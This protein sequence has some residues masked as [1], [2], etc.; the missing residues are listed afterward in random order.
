[1]RKSKVSRRKHSLLFRILILLCLVTALYFLQKEYK[2]EVKEK[3]IQPVKTRT[4]KKPSAP[5]FINVVAVIPLSGCFKCEGEAARQGIEI[6]IRN[7]NN[8]QKIKLSYWDWA[9][10]E[11]S[12]SGAPESSAR[13]T[14]TI[15]IVHMPF[16]KLSDFARTHSRALI[17]A[18]ACSH[19]S[20]KDMPNVITL[21]GTDSLEG[22]FVAD[23]FLHNFST[24]VKAVAIDGSDYSK[25]LLSS[26]KKSI[27][28]NVSSFP[29]V[30]LVA[31]DEAFQKNIQNLLAKKPG[32]I[33]LAGEPQ[34]IILTYKRLKNLGYRGKFIVPKYFDR[35]FIS[36]V[37]TEDLQNLLFIRPFVINPAS[38]FSKRFFSDFKKAYLSPPCWISAIFYDAMTI[39]MNTE[40]AKLKSL[41]K[42]LEFHG[43]T[44][45][46]ALK[47]H[48]TF[49]RTLYLAR[50]NRGSFESVFSLNPEETSSKAL[51]N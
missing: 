1:M 41:K 2:K 24:K 9:K 33:W 22:Q 17:I 40:P 23:I 12:P 34:W 35:F 43:A 15:Y 47:S 7:H 21:L 36:D 10:K 18:P 11:I 3:P 27:G 28:K 48:R 19:E 16:D 42:H 20:L 29:I 30:K 8:R 5:Y 38:P 46:I 14:Q 32:I 37:P 25:T 51:A 31:N 6:A 13:D 39:I 44:G 4:E 49:F 45:T 50:F 26:F